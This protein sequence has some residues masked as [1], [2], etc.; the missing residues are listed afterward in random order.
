MNLSGLALACSVILSACSSVPSDPYERRVYDSQQ[1]AQRAASVAVDN[2]PEWMTKLPVSTS[3]VYA[4]G[5][6]VSSDLAMAENKA[7]LV[8]FGKICMA[9][10]GRVD[11]RNQLFVQ[12]HNDVAVNSSEMAIRSMCPSVD[13]TG[14][15]IKEARRVNE[16]GRFRSYI[17][18]ALPLD[19][20]NV[21][22]QRRDRVRL[23]EN[24]QKRADQMFSTMDQPRQ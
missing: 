21:L 5:T 16:Q 4:T 8:A 22:Q 3:A 18:V 24:N 10:G 19:Q 17:L 7:K 2:A 6:A 1:Q 14:V 23:Q 15:E 11:Q 13:L 9:A 12:E 20:A